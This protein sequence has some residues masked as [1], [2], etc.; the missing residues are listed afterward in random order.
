V[1]ELAAGDLRRHVVAPL[2]E[3]E[4]FEGASHALADVARRASVQHEGHADVLFDAEVGKEPERLVDDADLAAAELRR[5][6]V[7]HGGDA[8]PVDVD[9]AARRTVEPGDELQEGRLAGAARAG[10]GDELT[11]GDRQRHVDEGWCL[12]PAAPIRLG[13]AVDDDRGAGGGLRRRVL[14][15]VLQRAG[16]SRV[17]FERHAL[18][19]RRSPLSS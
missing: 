5:L 18:P 13:D 11:G 19:T 6:V 9:A 2:P 10:H 1:L 4:A 14:V 8:A 15:V 7:A 3:A 12:D 16:T 17:A